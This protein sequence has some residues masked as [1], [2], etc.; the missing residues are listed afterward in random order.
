[1][2][3]KTKIIMVLLA[4]ALP[5]FACKKDTCQECSDPVAAN[6]PE[7]TKQCSGYTMTVQQC[8][9]GCC[10]TDSSQIS[11]SVDF[12]GQILREDIIGDTAVIKAG[13]GSERTTVFISGR[14]NGWI[15]KEMSESEVRC[16]ME[17]QLAAIRAGT[18]A[19]N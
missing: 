14:E 6:C 13:S 18:P 2:K 12:P 7:L 16:I 19:L 1:M 9:G 11:C 15:T 4:L 10:T 17:R 5:P 8:S 3:N